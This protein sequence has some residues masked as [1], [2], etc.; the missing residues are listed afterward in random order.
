LARLD[1]PRRF[2]SPFINQNNS[3]FIAF[4]AFPKIAFALTLVVPDHESPNIDPDKR[5]CMIALE[6]QADLPEKTSKEE[7]DEK[8]I[9]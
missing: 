6:S 3:S 1:Y 9:S 8:G 5:P 4:S 2:S 7:N